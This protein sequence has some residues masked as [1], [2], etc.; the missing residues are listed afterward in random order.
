MAKLLADYQAEVSGA[1]GLGGLVQDKAGD[2]ATA[3]RDRAIA[4]A[5]EQFSRVRPRLIVADVTGTGS[6]DYAPPTGWEEQFS[7]I[8]S[9]EFPTGNVPATLLEDGD[10][11][12]YRTTAGERIRLRTQQPTASEAF[13]VSFT[14]LHSVTATAGTIG[15]GNFRAVCHLAAAI[16][17]RM[18]AT[19]YSQA[20][21]PS[22]GADSVDHKSK[23]GEFAARS[24]E[25]LQIYRIHIG[26]QAET[27]APAA[28]YTQDWDRDFGWGEDRLTHPRRWR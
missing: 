7:T 13:R 17:C 8:L 10:Y 2:L 16:A 21:S 27:P 18:L 4:H 19:Q 25:L 22:L 14:G 9:I 15:D 24:R 23:A 3:D 20:T 5:A 6:N 1:D 11:E 26:A 12:I 28:S